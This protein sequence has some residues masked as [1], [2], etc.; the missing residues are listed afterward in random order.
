MEDDHLY[1]KAGSELWMTI[2]QPEYLLARRALKDIDEQ[3]SSMN[4]IMS[5]FM[6]SGGRQQ[7]AA[8]VAL[9]EE[10]AYDLGCAVE[11]IKCIYLYQDQTAVA[12]VDMPE[13]SK[14]VH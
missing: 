10:T 9:Y 7:W 2:E 4:R 5:T 14:N 6:M 3:K 13:G 11:Q 8:Y 1:N 12:V